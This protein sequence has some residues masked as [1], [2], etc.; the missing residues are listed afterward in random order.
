MLGVPA[1]LATGG[2]VGAVLGVLFGL[3]RGGAFTLFLVPAGMI[4][5]IANWQDRHPEALRST[6]GLD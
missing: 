6:S 3:R 4:G 1:L 5:Y 2:M